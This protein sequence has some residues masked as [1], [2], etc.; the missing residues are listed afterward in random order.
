MITQAEAD[1]FIIYSK[2]NPDKMFNPDSKW[3]IQYVEG[4]KKKKISYHAGMVLN[5]EL[6]GYMYYEEVTDNFLEALKFN[7]EYEAYYLAKF[8]NER[9]NILGYTK[10]MVYEQNETFKIIEIL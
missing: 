1:E 7:N 6:K 4:K 3:I 8:I 10:E 9:S 2:K 5:K